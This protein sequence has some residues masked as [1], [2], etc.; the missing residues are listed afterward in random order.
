[1]PKV[2]ASE[3]GVKRAPLGSQKEAELRNTIQNVFED[4][5]T[6]DTRVILEKLQ[7]YL[8]SSASNSP[9]LY[10]AETAN[11]QLNGQFS[12]QQPTSGNFGV[13]LIHPHYFGYSDWDSFGGV[14]GQ[15]EQ[16][17]VD[18]GTPDNLSGNSGFSNPLTVG[19]EAVHLI[20]GLGDFSESSVL[21]RW[22]FQVNKEPNTAVNV[23]QNMRNTDLQLQFLES[24]V[25]LTEDDNFAS[26]LYVGGE[27]GATYQPAPYLFGLSFV[28]SKPLRS[29]TPGDY[30]GSSVEGNI[31]VD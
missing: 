26:R 20:L 2:S 1:M 5:R 13:D 7:E 14:S 4:T 11:D 29:I 9:I 17:W 27:S 6:L 3:A 24:P 15:S 8:G 21:N 12:G 10:A 25:L 28:E 22:V 23:Q 19:S 18:A 31:L 16:D 30:V